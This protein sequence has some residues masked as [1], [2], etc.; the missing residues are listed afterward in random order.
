[1][2]T[3][4]RTITAGNDTIFSFSFHFKGGIKES[5]RAYQRW[6]IEN[7]EKTMPGLDYT[8]QQMF[9]ISAGQ[10]WCS[11]YREEA[12][13]NRVTTGV[14]SPGQFRVIGPMS[15]MKEFSDDFNCAVGSP[16]NPPAEDKCSVW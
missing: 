3:T 4:V 11:V 2:L 14:H 7:P 16:M 15:N 1:M 8:P 6:A 13:K 12:M 9:W 10:V 5:Y